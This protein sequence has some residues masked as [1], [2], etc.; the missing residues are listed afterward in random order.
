MNWQGVGAA[1]AAQSSSSPNPVT[2]DD[3]LKAYL[4][5][6]ASSAVQNRFAA[7]VRAAEEADGPS[8]A[9]AAGALLLAELAPVERAMRPVAFAARTAEPALVASVVNVISWADQA[10]AV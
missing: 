8:S 10:R 2:P 1:M 7:G 9:V 6:S 4:Q 5:R 3:V